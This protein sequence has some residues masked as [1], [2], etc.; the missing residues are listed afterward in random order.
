MPAVGDERGK[1]MNA[2]QVAVLK[3]HL[4]QIHEI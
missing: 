3:V 2:T 4:H 1:K